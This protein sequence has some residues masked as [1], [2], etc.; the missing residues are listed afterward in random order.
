[1]VS[2]A[3]P[4]FCAVHMTWGAINELT[5]LN[6]YRR[7]AALTDHPVLTDLVERIAL[8]ESRHFFFYYRQA[9]MR[10]RRRA[11]AGSA[12]WW[13]VLGPGRQGA[14]RSR[15]SLLATSLRRAEGRAAR[16]GGRHDPAPARLR[17]RA[18]PESR[19]D[20]TWGAPASPASTQGGRNGHHNH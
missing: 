12:A 3:W 4:S 6:G 2:K 17:D 16:Q 13:T 9:E 5:T 15:A 19:M 7:L 11:V 20:D 18:A 8:D 10:L 1:M 14:A